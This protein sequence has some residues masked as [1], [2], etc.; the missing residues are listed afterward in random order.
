MDRM[1]ALLLIFVLVSTASAQTSPGPTVLV[2]DENGV[3]VPSARIFLQAPPA[4]A[5]KCQTDHSGRCHFPNLAPGAYHL[6]VEKEGYYALDEAQVQLAPGAG[7]EVTISHEQEV[8]E[9]VDV[10]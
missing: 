2:V 3:A 10:H 9:V 4:L 8:Q 1:R 7:V 5:V 6:R